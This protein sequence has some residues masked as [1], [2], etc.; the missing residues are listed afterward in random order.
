VTGP[1]TLTAYF[2][3]RERVGG[4]FLAEQILDLFDQKNVATSVMLRGI[5]S[6]GPTNVI[7]GDRSLSLSEDP[8]VTIAAVDTAQRITTVAAGVATMIGRGVLTLEQSAPAGDGDVRLTVYLG[9]RHEPGFVDVCEV[10]HSLGFLSA[11]VHLG[12]D[13][14]VSGRRE[15]ARFFSRNVD[16]PLVVT[17]V[18][19]AAQAT[20]A[21]AEIGALRAD[22]LITVDPIRV[23]KNGGRTVGGLGQAVTAYRRLT[24]HTAEDDQVGGRPVHRALI[25]HLKEST[26]AS[27]ATAVR[28]IW[29][30]RGGQPPH[31]DRFFQ[32]TRRV[33]VST[34]MIDTSDSIAATYSIVDEVTAGAGLVTVEDLPAVW[35]VHGEHSRGSLDLG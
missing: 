3:E 6:F 18:G 22:A 24:V 23:C 16:V 10:L 13:G 34:V 32:L 25:R 31:G 4:R 19:T 11:Q 28:G 5:A 33:P 20:A 21:T 17:G 14:T 7:R 2:A 9:R 8:P 1:V 15:R 27:G 12:V 35:S 29:G 30:F 26:H